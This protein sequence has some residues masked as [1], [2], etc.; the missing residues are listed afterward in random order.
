MGKE[1]KAATVLQNKKTFCDGTHLQ[2]S[3]KDE[4]DMTAA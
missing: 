3:F 1:C 2:T 4:K